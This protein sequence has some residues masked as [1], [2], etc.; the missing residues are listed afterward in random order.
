MKRIW[1]QEGVL[2]GIYALAAILVSIQRLWLTH[3]KA[4]PY[5]TNYENYLIFKNAFRHLLQGQNIYASFPG[6]QWDLYKY[7]PAFA[8]GMAPFHALPDFL[9]LPLWNLLNALL[10]LYALMQLKGLSKTQQI[11]CAWFIFPEMLVSLQNSQ[12]NGLTL[13]LILLSF[14]ALESQR[15]IQAA[16]GVAAA[17]FLKV[18][19][20]FAA[21]L[22]WIYPNRLKFSLWLLVWCLFFTCIPL[23]IAS[24]TYLIQLYQWWGVLLN[25]DHAASIGLSVQGW[26]QTWFGL[27]PPKL[28]ISIF[29]ILSL[30]LTRYQ[31]GKNPIW[32][33]RL[34]LWASLLIWVVIFNHKAESPTFV[35]ALCGAALWYCSLAKPGKWDT[36][37]LALVFI[38]AS[39][40]PTDLFPR[41]WREQWVQPYV[42]KAAPCIA[43]WIWITVR[44]V[45]RLDQRQAP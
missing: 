1:Q 26:L 9:G 20:I 30:L 14:A 17:T 27:M 43:L 22:A 2:W 7:S 4:V 34:A 11:F 21:P 25:E 42:L 8:L 39:L 16:G 3:Q 6:E 35:I 5:P 37:L 13:G 36:G 40:T 29:G 32:P 44:L 38:F 41:M 18:F 31:T 10:P 24:P 23:V 19:G 45:W 28:L 15:Q 33:N 12:S